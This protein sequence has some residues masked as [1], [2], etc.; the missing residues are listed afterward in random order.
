MKCKR[1]LL[2]IVILFITA[3]ESLEE[4]VESN[5]MDKSNLDIQKIDSII[6]TF[7]PF[8]KKAIAIPTF[9]IESD[10]KNIVKK[11]ELKKES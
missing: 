10:K 5:N 11:V 2:Y 3:A 4:I 7:G 9:H 8:D 1:I 6:N